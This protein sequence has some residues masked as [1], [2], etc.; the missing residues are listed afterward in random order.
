MTCVPQDNTAPLVWS[1]RLNIMLGTCQGL[2][3]LHN[4][5]EQPLIHGDIKRLDK[6]FFMPIQCGV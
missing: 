3:F 2:N 6:V 1:Q 5:G 4:L